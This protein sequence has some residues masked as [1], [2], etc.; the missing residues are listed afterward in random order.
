MTNGDKINTGPPTDLHILIAPLDWGL[1]HATR[2]VPIVKMLIARYHTVILAAEGKQADLL[3]QEFPNLE[4]VR[5][6]GYRLTYSAFR[7]LTGWKIFFQIPKI[8]ISIKRENQWLD[9]LLQKKRIDLVISD[10][11]FGLHNKTVRTVFITHQL[12]IKSPIG[13]WTEN[14]L[15]KLNYH[16]INKFNECWVPDFEGKQNLAGELSHP[17]ALPQTP[18]KYI[19]GLSRFDTTTQHAETKQYDVLIVL[20]GPEPQRSIWEKKLFNDL[21]H[22]S[23]KAALVRGLPGEQST[24]QV[25]DVDVYNH[26]SADQLCSIALRSEIVISRPGYTTVMDLV[27]LRKKSVL[28]PTPGQSE[29]EY[30]GEYLMQQQLCV[31]INQQQ[32][33]IKNAMLSALHFPYKEMNGFNMELYNEVINSLI[34]SL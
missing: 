13:R 3:R 31:C 11:R 34:P 6:Q 24:T 33:S 9:T 2:C 5:L 20:S 29:Q 21:E 22:Y 18:V 23:G 32:F 8:L 12:T 30:L 17:P 19:G 28:V 14:F 7:N 26:L 1:G 27:K 25:K 16:F 10:C 4:L 15:R